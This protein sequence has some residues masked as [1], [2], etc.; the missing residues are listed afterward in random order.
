M[1]SRQKRVTSAIALFLV[2]STTQVYVG[3]SFAGPQPSIVRLEVASPLPQQA[4][5]VLSTDGNKPITL[6]GTPAIGGA[7]LLSGASIETPPGV[8][9]SVNLGTLGWLKIDPNTKLSLEF[10]TGRVRLMLLQGCV[11]VHTKKGTSSEVDTLQ[12]VAARNDDSK[13]G[14]ATAC[15]PGSVPV[16]A[17]AGAGAGGA[18]AGAAAGGG[19]LLGLGTAG[20][21]AVAVLAGTFVVAPIATRG[22]NPSPSAP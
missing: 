21:I 7:T 19:G 3:I 9:G 13:D 17:G 10:Q 6:N 2:F 12:G 16:G 15:A 18:G 1:N 11:A 5:A 4:T 20:T 8:G 22:R 14:L